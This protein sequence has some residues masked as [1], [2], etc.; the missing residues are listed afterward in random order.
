MNGARDREVSAGHADGG[1]ARPPAAL[2][3]AAA[4]VQ[5][6]MDGIAAPDAAALGAVAVVPSRRSG[7]YQ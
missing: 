3:T 5:I 1:V 7:Q 6:G 4:R 2:F